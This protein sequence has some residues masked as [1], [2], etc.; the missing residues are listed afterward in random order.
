MES[1]APSQ[2]ASG[3]ARSGGPADRS[4]AHGAAAAA[5]APPGKPQQNVPSTESK[6]EKPK[7][8]ETKQE[9][10]IKQEDGPR[11]DG[12]TGE[13]R[14]QFE[15]ALKSLENDEGEEAHLS[16]LGLV[17]EDAKKIAGTVTVPWRCARR[18]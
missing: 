10:S 8:L 4:E 12:K 9:K 14:Q 18:T 11:E 13:R 2:R 17:A 5:A 1:A 3:S 15:K 7:P 16:G 6:K